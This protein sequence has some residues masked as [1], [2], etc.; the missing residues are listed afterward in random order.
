MDLQHFIVLLL[1]LVH[2]VISLPARSRINFGRKLRQEEQ[3]QDEANSKPDPV[4][5][6]LRYGYVDFEEIGLRTANGTATSS[7]PLLGPK[8]P[9]V[10]A[11][12][13]RFQVRFVKKLIFFA[14]TNSCSCY[15]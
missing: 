11:A 5:Y 10:T 14:S 7:L 3:E 8:S 4:S 13:K 15:L 6:L 1:G 2:C 12:L 9:E